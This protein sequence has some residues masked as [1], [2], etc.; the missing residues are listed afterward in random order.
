M[1]YHLL[2]MTHRHRNLLGRSLTVAHFFSYRTETV[3]R[4]L[5]TF[6]PTKTLKACRRVGRKAFL[7]CVCMRMSVCSCTR[8]CVS[9]C[10]CVDS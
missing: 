7:M 1:S 2:Y 8:V 4:F 10:A 3:L 5:L 9:A 6:S